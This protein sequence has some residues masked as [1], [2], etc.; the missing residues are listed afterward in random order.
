MST[1][2]DFYELRISFDAQRTYWRERFAQ[3][4]EWERDLLRSSRERIDRSRE[5]LART[6][7][8]ASTP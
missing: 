8:K 5:L 4:E 6:R 2:S 1:D 7:P 3:L